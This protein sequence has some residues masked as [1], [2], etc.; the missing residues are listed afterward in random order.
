MLKLLL[1]WGSD[2]MGGGTTIL[3]SFPPEWSR[4]DLTSKQTLESVISI[5]VAFDL[6]SDSNEPCE[7]LLTPQ[8]A[9][10]H[11][12]KQMEPQ[13]KKET[14]PPWRARCIL[15][16]FDLLWRIGIQVLHCHLCGQEIWTCC[17][18]S[19]HAGNLLLTYVIKCGLEYVVLVVHFE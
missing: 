4:P 16:V 7:K 14:N 8:A 5:Y 11:R 10:V 19:H 13:P 17:V 15:L 2:E 12:E 9:A 3:F 6:R 18:E 1:T